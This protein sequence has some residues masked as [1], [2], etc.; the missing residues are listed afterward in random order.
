MA[1][2]TG[3]PKNA[4]PSTTNA[5]GQMLT[6]ASGDSRL[7]ENAAGMAARATARP[8]HRSDASHANWIAITPMETGM[9]ISLTHEGRPMGRIL[10]SIRFA[11]TTWALAYARMPT[12]AAA[13]E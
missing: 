13:T 7:S 11:I 1:T 8:H 9:M 6:A 2:N 12:T 4:A 3:A 10:G 5:S